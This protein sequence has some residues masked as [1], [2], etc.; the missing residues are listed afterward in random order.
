[1]RC[2]AERWEL[3]PATGAEFPDHS[4]RERSRCRTLFAKAQHAEK[5]R[6]AMEA[7][8]GAILSGNIV[9]TPSRQNEPE[10][11]PAKVASIR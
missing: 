4:I 2:F 11:A 1:M 9:E 10:R 5:H 6:E 3:P 8:F 7:T